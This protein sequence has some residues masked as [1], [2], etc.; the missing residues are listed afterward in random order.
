MAFDRDRAAYFIDKTGEATAYIESALGVKFDPVP[1]H[2]DS[3]TTKCSEM[4]TCCVNETRHLVDHGDFTCSESKRWYK[5]SNCCG[6]NGTLN[7]FQTW[8]SYLHLKNSLKDSVKHISSA[9][10]TDIRTLSLIKMMVTRA[11]QE[12]STFIEHTVQDVQKVNQTWV[13]RLS[14]S[15]IIKGT[16][17]VF[18]S[19]GFGKAAT[20]EECEILGINSTNEVHAYNSGILWNLTKTNDW[21]KDDLNAWYL[22]FVENAP[23]WFLW[24]SKA[25]VLSLTGD[26]IYDESASY[27]ERGRI[28]KRKGIKEAYYITYD[29]ASNTTVQS[30]LGDTAS[31]NILNSA[32]VKSC[33]TRSKRLWKNFIATF[34]GVGDQ[35]DKS[36]CSA[37]VNPQTP[38]KIRKIKQGIIDTISGP[39]VDKYQRII[40]TDNAHACGNAASPGLFPTYLA[41]GSTLG[42][43]LVGGFIAG[44]NIHEDIA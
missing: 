17:I 23:Q 19:G 8:P 38:V 36:E 2:D 30:E 13:L 4:P 9:G 7:E 28:A 32:V 3:V 10:F 31:Q 42:N 25:T 26:L 11:T 6:S 37:R 21:V 40:S 15:E 16:N 18:G 12:N 29:P 39:V 35:A 20:Q 44:Q 5:G 43:A 14:N 27:D 24:D 33:D 34:Y 41:P 1:S 22:E